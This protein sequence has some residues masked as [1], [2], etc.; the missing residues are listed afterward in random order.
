M[1]Q[2]IFIPFPLAEQVMVE[3]KKRQVSVEKIITEAIKKFIDKEK[4][5]VNGKERHHGKNRR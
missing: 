3:A 1:E 4:K 5:N 2:E